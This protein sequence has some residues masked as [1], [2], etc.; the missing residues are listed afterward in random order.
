MEFTVKELFTLGRG[1]YSR[2]MAVT[3][4][5][6][7]FFVRGYVGQRKVRFLFLV[8][9]RK[10]RLSLE[11]FCM[12]VEGWVRFLILDQERLRQR[13]GREEEMLVV[14]KSKEEV[15]IDVIEE[16]FGEESLEEIR[17]RRIVVF[18][19]ISWFFWRASLEL[20]IFSGGF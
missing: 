20:K 16:F 14:K 19:F 18:Y 3:F 10:G 12:K 15:M 13:C 8:T 5:R 17:V 4:E 11:V 1:I 7:F 6:K 9:F 2:K